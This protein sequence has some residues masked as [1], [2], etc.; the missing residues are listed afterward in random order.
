MIY[1]HSEVK[2]LSGFVVDSYLD[3]SK[4]MAEA[5]R[6]AIARYR[7][8]VSANRH[9]CFTSWLSRFFEGNCKMIT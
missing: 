3:R 6:S 7:Q 9:S 8:R 1:M 5:Q 4:V 2:L